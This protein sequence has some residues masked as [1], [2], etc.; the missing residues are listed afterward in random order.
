[1]LHWGQDMLHASEVLPAGW[2]AFCSVERQACGAVEGQGGSR[3]SPARQVDTD[4]YLHSNSTLCAQHL[5]HSSKLLTGRVHELYHSRC[6]HGMT[7]GFVAQV[8]G[9]SHNRTESVPEQHRV[10]SDRDQRWPDI[11]CLRA[12][13]PGDTLRKLQILSGYCTH[14]ACTTCRRSVAIRALMMCSPLSCR[15]PPAYRVRQRRPTGQLY[16]HQPMP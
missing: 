2:T 15:D 6:R 5:S 10:S 13:V 12:L 9:Q 8:H 4:L 16:C 1:M 3:Y 14:R 7:A 11:L